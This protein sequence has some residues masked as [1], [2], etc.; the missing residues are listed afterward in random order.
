MNALYALQIQM[1]NTKKLWQ[2]QVVCNVPDLTLTPLLAL[3]TGHNHVG[4]LDF[5]YAE[6]FITHI[7]LK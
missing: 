4:K 6:T 3:D 7:I 1:S 5:K 2:Q